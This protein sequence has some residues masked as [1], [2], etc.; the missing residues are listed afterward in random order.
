MDRLVKSTEKLPRYTLRTWEFSGVV[1][2]FFHYLIVTYVL[3][4]LKINNR[5]STVLINTRRK[6]SR[7]RDVIV[8]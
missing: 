4:L 5:A 6:I 8:L 3:L 2:F 7:Y 1:F